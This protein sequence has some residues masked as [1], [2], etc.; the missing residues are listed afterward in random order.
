MTDDKTM[1]ARLSAQIAC[2]RASTDASMYTLWALDAFRRGEDHSG[3][4]Y[5]M[6]A[7]EAKERKH[8][9]FLEWSAA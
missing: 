9:A 7:E 4:E 2:Y 5:L 1:R 8:D 3:W 6:W